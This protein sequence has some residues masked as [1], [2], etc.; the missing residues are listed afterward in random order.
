MPGLHDGQAAST[1]NGA[2]ALMDAVGWPVICA[3][4]RRALREVPG[5]AV[6]AGLSMGAG[7][8]G[9]VRGQ[10][11]RSAGIVLPHAIVRAPMPT[12]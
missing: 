8:T 12:V 1:T 4:A 3:R 7:V 6:L 10:R 5:T 11:D 2:L 9:S